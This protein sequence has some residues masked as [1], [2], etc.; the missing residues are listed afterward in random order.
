MKAFANVRANVLAYVQLK[1]EH[2][3]EG[4]LRHKRIPKPFMFGW[5]WLFSVLKPQ[6]KAQAHR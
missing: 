2:M 4:S 5:A 3:N 6:V 1:P